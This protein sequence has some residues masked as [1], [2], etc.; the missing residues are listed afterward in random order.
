MNTTRHMSQDDLALFALQLL[1]GDELREA[2]DHLEHCE[3]CRHDVARY[4]GDL[5]AYAL[6]GSEMHTPPAQARERL[7]KAVSREKKVVPM[8]QRP[9]SYADRSS[10]S[11]PIAADPNA[12]SG[13]LFLAGRNRRT[14]EPETREPRAVRA[15]AASTSSVTPF[16]G[17]AGWAIAAG[18]AVVAGLQFHQRQNL[19]GDLN[20]AAARLTD[21]D[22]KLAEAQGA[23]QTLTGA[24]A[25]QVSLHIPVGTQPE[26]PKPEGHVAYS[27]DRGALVF[28]AD[29]LDPLQPEK[30]Y[31]LWLIPATGAPIPAGTFK[32]DARGIATVVMPELP[33]GVPAK[34]FGVTIEADGGS[35]TPTPPIVLAGM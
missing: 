31:E 35:K 9:V 20:A 10:G 25:L 17:W 28:I 7:L 14:F 8:A 15:A 30:T 34:G 18:L 24:G 19:Q 2:L 12:D 4:Q 5:V 13:E 1:E 11:V 21:S 6:A 3:E 29:H 23:L 22:A 33:K 32:P 27:A 16:L 26:P